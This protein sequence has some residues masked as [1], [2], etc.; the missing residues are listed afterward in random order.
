MTNKLKLIIKEEVEHFLFEM[1][2]DELPLYP[3]ALKF[4]DYVHRN[5][6]RKSTGDKYINH[7]VAVS[8]IL[9]QWGF[10]TWYQAVS[11]LHDVIEEAL[12]PNIVINLIKK[13]FGDK[14]LKVVKL[15]SHD[16]GT[17]YNEYLLNLCKTNKEA[18]IIKFADIWANLHDN[19][20]SKQ[21]TK[22]INSIKYLKENGIDFIPKK[23]LNMI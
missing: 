4:A 22:Y 2:M 9:S 23:L 16:A 7:P 6:P 19:P 20:T 21:K 11:I 14:I 5:Q 17:D 15:L 12:N 13:Y 18:A 10:N 3:R 8:M 1:A